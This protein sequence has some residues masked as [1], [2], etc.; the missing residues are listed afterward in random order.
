GDP[1]SDPVE[2]F[3]DLDDDAVLDQ[4]RRA[5]G[6]ALAA[7]ITTVRDL[8]DRGFSTVALRDELAWAPWLAPEILVA[9]PPI[10]PPRGHCW[11]LGG[12][13]ANSD[14]E[15]AVEERHERGVDVIKIMATGGK[16]TPGS[17]PHKSQFDR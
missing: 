4:A 12:E 8:G 17:A 2:Q 9:G 6:H 10:T 5:A 13:T 7:G 11:F 15:R 14:V 1:F 16:I 3:R